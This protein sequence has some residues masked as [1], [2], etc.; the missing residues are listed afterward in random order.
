[1][2]AVYLAG[3]GYF[4]TSQSDQLITN[5]EFFFL[6]LYCADRLVG[7]IRAAG[8]TADSV[9]H[10]GPPPPPSPS[11]PWLQAAAAAAAAACVTNMTNS[12]PVYNPMVVQQSSAAPSQTA[13]ST[14]TSPSYYNFN[15]INLAAAA[16]GGPAGGI[17]A[18]N[19]P[20][21]RRGIIHSFVS[22]PIG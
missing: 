5:I 20:R 6:S 3:S 13:T 4:C 14:L 22:C 7:E 10:H 2:A 8:L 19:R 21:A 12:L 9:R 17:N 16:N 1:M 15:G 11:Y 18:V